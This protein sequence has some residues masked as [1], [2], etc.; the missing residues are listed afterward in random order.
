MAEE[1]IP[2]GRYRRLARVGR[3][4]STQAAREAGT[5]AV[6]LVRSDEA[7]SAAA[8]RR[9]VQAAEQV[10]GVL[11][12]MKGASMK[13]GQLLSFLNVGL[14]EEEHRAVFQQKLA[15]LRDAAP[16]VPFKSMR[17]V[18][19][20]DLGNR[21]G[22]TFA[23][24]QE[25]PVASASIGQVYRAQ[26]RD[27]REVAVKVQYPGVAAAVRAD[28][29]N[30]GM[31]MRLFAG[32]A[33]QLDMKALAKEARTE[34]LDELD[35]ELEAS[36]QRALARVY[37]GHPFIF[38]PSVVPDLC[39]ERVIVMDF[40]EGD[41]FAVLEQEP[42]SERNRIA[43]IAFRFYFGAMY[44]HNMFSGD[45]HPGNLLRRKDG[46]IAFLDFGLVKRMRREPIEIT[47]GILRSLVE[48]DEAELLR[49]LARDGF[50]H[51]PS[52]FAP[53]EL[54]TY[55]LDAYW[56]CIGA[57][58]EVTVTPALTAELIDRHLLPRAPRF[59]TTRRLDINAEHV[60]GRRLELFVLGLLGQ[61]KASANWHRIARE[62]LYGDPPVTE[63][64]RREA[65]FLAQSRAGVSA[66]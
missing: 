39:G 30:L 40:V 35:Y 17:Q 32:I 41:E 56:W 6:N 36:N 42:E 11:G 55:M 22:A 66:E 23:D 10:V 58:R 47:L 60:L 28:M 34:I 54:M 18:I 43:E 33:P 65:G 26:L 37:D 50:L 25:E 59:T 13:L 31:I 2:T 29:Q 51:D 3:A 19:E 46:S 64:G 45:P 53:A 9:R 1:R 49:L 57:D 63:L 48:E 61:L 8:E 12:T 38:I 7:A 14:V 16:A 24:F 27:G 44:R 5:R 21:L 15:A 52:R 62:W 4:A 20:R